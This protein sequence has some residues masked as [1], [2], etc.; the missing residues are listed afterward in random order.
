M[1]S[2]QKPKKLYS[3]NHIRTGDALLVKSKA[4]WLSQFINFISGSPFVHAAIAVRIDRHLYVVECKYSN[5]YSYQMMPIDWWLARNSGDHLFIGKMPEKR[6]PQE[7]RRHVRDTVMS[8]S[9]S[10]R[11]YRI[12]WLAVVYFIQVWLGKSRPQFN[13]LF[14]KNKPLICSTLV[15]EA[16]E[17]AGVISEG[18]YMTP[19]DL[20]SMLG[21]ESALAP[22]YQ[23]KPA[24]VQI[25][26]AASN[27]SNPIDH[28]LARA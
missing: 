11:N 2:T 4:G 8:T 28:H 23:Q 13:R 19:G 9:E 25:A 10:S 24:R 15:Q 3:S 26:L 5:R 12:S 21:G 6:R 16:W 27:D 17:R 20:V 22:V 7:A 14:Q 18:D 1:P